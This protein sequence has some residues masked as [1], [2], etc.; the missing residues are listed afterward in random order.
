M[1]SNLFNSD[2]KEAIRKFKEQTEIDE[3]TCYL[4]LVPNVTA[5]KA[6]DAPDVVSGYM[7]RGYRYG[8]IYNELTN[9]RTIAHDIGHDTF[10]MAQLSTDFCT[11]PSI[12]N[13]S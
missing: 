7:P 1:R 5:K 10:L 12:P 13:P 4:F 3:E 6:D 2:Q 11:C 9:I 8:F